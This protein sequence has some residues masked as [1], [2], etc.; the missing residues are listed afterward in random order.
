MAVSRSENQLKTLGLDYVVA[1]L[2]TPEG[3]AHAVKE[4]RDRLGP[5]SILVCNH[6]IGSAHER[7]IWEQDPAVWQETMRINLDGPFYLSK[8]VVT[9][10]IKQGYGRIVYTS[11]TAGQVA[12]YE[13][14]AYNSSKHGLLGLMRSL[15][16]DAGQYGVTSNAVLP[17]W[18]RTEMAE[19]SAETEAKQRRITTEEVWEERA[20]LAPAGRVVTPKEVAE[21][22]AFLASEEASGLNGE[23]ITVALGSLS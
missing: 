6:G 20:S 11:S 9:D 15:A 16:Q 23:A 7:V 18:V 8:E 22:I 2:G 21:V 14:S 1:D 4:T 19:K 17:G 13:G 5:V 3:C 10:M 12:E